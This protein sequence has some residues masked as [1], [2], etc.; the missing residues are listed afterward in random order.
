MPAEQM[1]CY[2]KYEASLW[3]NDIAFGL[4]RSD[5]AFSCFWGSEFLSW[6][7]EQ[8][9]VRSWACCMIKFLMLLAVDHICAGFVPQTR[10]HFDIHM[11]K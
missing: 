4:R 6:L 1:H 11:L 10:R 8:F 7:L 9:G 3:G 5:Y 2:V